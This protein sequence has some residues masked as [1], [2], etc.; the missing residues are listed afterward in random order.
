MTH[1][2]R[3]AAW[4]VITP[5]ATVLTAPPART[6]PCPDCATPVTECFGDVMKG[7]RRHCR[8]FYHV[9]TGREPCAAGGAGD[10]A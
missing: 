10:A 3:A 6:R 7:H 2:F 8:G 4:T 5:I 9:A 1:A